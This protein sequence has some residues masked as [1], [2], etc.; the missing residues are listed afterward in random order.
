MLIELWS[1]VP[2]CSGLDKTNHIGYALTRNGCGG[3]VSSRFSPP[4]DG[5]CSLGG[6]R[7]QGRRT[8]GA[9]AIGTRIHSSGVS[10]QGMTARTRVRTVAPRCHRAE[11]TVSCDSPSVVRNDSRTATL[12]WFEHPRTGCRPLLH[13]LWRNLAFACGYSPMPHTIRRPGRSAACQAGAQD[14]LPFGQA[15]A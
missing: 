4:L 11:W 9:G 15:E 3:R 8:S 12:V 2:P 10:P 14:K 5:R 7:R 1:L 13:F 6:E